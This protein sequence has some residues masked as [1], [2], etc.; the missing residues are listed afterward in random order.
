MRN[1]LNL[2]TLD[3][4]SLWKFNI[5]PCSGVPHRQDILFMLTST[6]SYSFIL[7]NMGKYVPLLQMQNASKQTVRR[8]NIN[9]IENFTDL[10]NWAYIQ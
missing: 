10:A 5:K 6:R 1:T 9:K 3:Y 2:I 7:E 4:Q 8:N